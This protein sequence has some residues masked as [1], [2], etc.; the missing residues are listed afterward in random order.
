MIAN[1][2][3]RFGSRILAKYLTKTVKSYQPFSVHRTATLKSVLQPGDV[4]LVEGDHRISS[5][6]KYLTQ[7]TWS[8]AAF[9]S[10]QLHNPAQPC[11]EDCVLIEADLENG[12]IAVPVEKYSKYN[13]RICRPVNL[14][15]SDLEKLCTYMADSIGKEYDLKNIVDLARYLLPNPPVP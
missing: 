10:G 11:D 6:I 14:T 9:Y 13:I 3:M 15:E 4:L 1:P 8:H 12:V 7:S 5:A 2:I